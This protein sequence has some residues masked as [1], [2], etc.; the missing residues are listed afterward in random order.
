MQYSPDLLPSQSAGGPSWE[1]MVPTGRPRTE[2]AGK[3][4]PNP[5]K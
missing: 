4:C 1:K 2:E 3:Y 5:I